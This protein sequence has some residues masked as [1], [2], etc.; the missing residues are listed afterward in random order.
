MK[1]VAF[2]TLG[3]KVNQYE[4]NGMTAK[5]LEYG[6]SIVE[7]GE[8]ADIY[9]INTCTVTAMSDK[10]SRTVIRRAKSLNEKGNVVVTGCYSETAKEEVQKISEVDLIV[11]NN[12]KKDIVEIVEEYI[13]NSC[14]GGFPY[15]PGQKGK[16][17]MTKAVEQEEFMDFGA[18]VSIDRTR[19]I[20]KVQDGCD[21]FCAYCIIPYAKGRA[22]SR[23]ID[24]VISEIK[25]AVEKG[26]KEVVITGIEISSYG[27]G[28]AGN[29]S[30]IDLLEEVNNIEGLER[31][32][33]GSLEPN[34]IS[35]DF[36]SR[37]SKLDKIC[38]H[39]HLS[40]QSG[41][42]ETLKRMNRKYSVKEFEEKVT[43][44]R[45]AFPD[46]ALTTDIIVGF[47][48]ETEEEFKK[49]YEFLKEIGFSKMHVFKYS[50]RKG[51]VA[52]RMENQIDAKEK[53]IRSKKLIE[54]SDRN[55]K[56]F[57]KQYINRKVLVLF[58][59]KRG[60]VIKGHTSNYIV[61]KSICK[62]DVS[63]EIKTVE[64]K[65]QEGTEL[66]GNIL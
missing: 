29:V 40:L 36:V 61:V 3:C 19:L 55:E 31:I 60:S 7:F 45:S 41:C 23:R 53:E 65:K 64:I 39:F 25:C 49:T 12:E 50:S 57:I 20:I 28:L 22:R 15:P 51:T 58:E 43:L 11:G 33:L 6:Y 47:P 26:V 10:K 48:G 38:N 56:E 34:T 62:A 46:M 54:L 44:L 66:I 30:L 2:Y 17:L 42:D 21:N 4:T 52:S 13:E 37:L 35:L 14:R 5:F 32:R 1:T 16:K 59:K 63:N 9:V 18:T 8:I 27:K 24:S